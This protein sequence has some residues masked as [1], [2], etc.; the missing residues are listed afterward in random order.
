MSPS[1]FSIIKGVV[2]REASLSAPMPDSRGIIISF[3]F[4][5][6]RTSRATMLHHTDLAYRVRD[7]HPHADSETPSAPIPFD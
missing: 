3:D 5:T 2:F 1:P 4:D 6:A 7:P